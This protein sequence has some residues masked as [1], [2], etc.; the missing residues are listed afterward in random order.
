M[1]A[2]GKEQ[3]LAIVTNC[4]FASANSVSLEFFN[5]L[6]SA[7]QNPCAKAFGFSWSMC[8]PKS[9]VNIWNLG[10]PGG[11]SGKESACQCRRHKRCGFDPWVRKIPLEEGMATHSSSLAWRMLWTEEPG[12]LQSIGSQRVGHDWAHPFRIISK[13]IPYY[14]ASTRVWVMYWRIEK[15]KIL[16]F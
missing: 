5:V 15:N 7:L 9:C 11:T 6:F 3:P 16:T 13:M 4:L 1:A 14:F 10:F 12:R 2:R 8:A